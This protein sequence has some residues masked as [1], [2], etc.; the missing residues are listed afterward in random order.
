[1]KTVGGLKC[2]NFLTIVLFNIMEKNPVMMNTI[3]RKYKKCKCKWN[4]FKVWHVTSKSRGGA[5]S[6][7]V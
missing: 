6:K 1:M 7:F 2:S 3:I 4:F 5:M